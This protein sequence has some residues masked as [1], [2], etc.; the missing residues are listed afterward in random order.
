MRTLIAI[1]CWDTVHTAF[2]KSVLGMQLTGEC[3]YTMVIGTLVYDARNKLAEKAVKDGFDRVLWLDSDMVFGRDLFQRLSARLDEGYDIVT[4]LYFAR[5][6]PFKPVVYK[7]CYLKATDSGAEPVAESYEDYPTDG[8]FEVASC[9]FGACMMN[10]G[11]LK[12]ITD[13]FGA[14]FSPELG[15]G[16]DFSFCRRASELGYRMWCDPAIKL[17]HMGYVPITEDVYKGALT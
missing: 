10:A 4:G 6:P 9:G 1:P 13:N 7:S 12:E 2:F 16:E 11:I 15:F 17:G 8:I 14:P 5:K 3:E